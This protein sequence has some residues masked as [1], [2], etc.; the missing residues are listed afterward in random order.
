MDNELYLQKL[1]N[2][3]IQMGENYVMAVRE[4]KPKYEI[5]HITSTI[6]SVLAEIKAVEQEVNRKIA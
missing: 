6:R 4:H 5:R 1:R 2:E 3:Y